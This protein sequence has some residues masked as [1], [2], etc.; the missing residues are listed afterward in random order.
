MNS[1]VKLM[2]ALAAIVLQFGMA[3][4]GHAALSAVGP[5]D[6]VTGFPVFYQ[7]GNGVGIELCTSAADAGNGNLCLL[8]AEPPF[9]NGAPPLSFTPL[10]FP[11]ELFWFTAEASVPTAAGDALY[12]AALEAAFANEDPVNGDQV[13]FARI[14]IRVDV[15]AP[16]GNYTVIHPYGVNVFQNVAPGIRAINFTDD[17]GLAPPPPPNFNGA[18]AGDIGPFLRSSTGDVIVGA[19]TFIGDPNVPSTVVG[20][21]LG[22]NF[23]RIEGPNIGGPGIDFVQ[24][25]DFA[26]LGKLFSGVLPTPLTLD[27][28]T[29]SR[30]AAGVDLA[31]FAT[32]AAT[33]LLTVS[34]TPAPA[35]PVVMDTNGTGNFF[36]D[37]QNLAA[38]PT[39]V[40]VTADPG[41][42]GL[43]TTLSTAPA[44]VVQIT[45]ADFN[46]ISRTLTI[47]ARSSD[48]ATGAAAPTLT[49]VGFGPLIAGTL[50]VNIPAP[51][52]PPPSATVTS[53]GG[54]V[55]S[56]LV[57]IGSAPLAGGDTVGII[58][59][60]FARRLSAWTILGTG[61]VPGNSIEITLNGQSIGTANVLGNRR[62]RLIVRG[63]PVVAVAGDSITA[64][65]NGQ[66]TANRA[67][68]VR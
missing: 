13:S 49:A 58:R 39:V 43:P 38:L 29:Y 57:S 36:A 47:S 28:V 65:S 60:V 10:N 56:H 1:R 53:S 25:N 19:E 41:A 20:S 9:F 63:S 26:L 35:P 15:P 50:S 59:A 37:I 12:V 46:T 18:L 23:F 7:D 40:S 34:G 64:T 32:S 51:G 27:R 21:P 4:H 68:V 30:D 42:G 3:Q 61:T 14:R 31:V 2:M 5:V 44:D 24:V 11:S 45:R 52:T 16:G 67:V 33:A 22:T 8:A 17:V 48:A 6:P 54:G 66:G 62:W 55:D